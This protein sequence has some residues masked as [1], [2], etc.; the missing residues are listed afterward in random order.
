M[1]PSLVAWFYLLFFFYLK[2]I[3]LLLFIFPFLILSSAV[4]P[5]INV[6]FI[7]LFRISSLMGVSNPPLVAIS[8]FKLTF[9]WPLVEGSHYLLANFFFFFFL[10][11]LEVDKTAAIINWLSLDC[12]NFG[13]RR[14][15]KLGRSLTGTGV[16]WLSTAVFR[17]VAECVSRCS[18]RR[19]PKREKKKKRDCLIWKCEASI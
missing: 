7:F 3:I 2:F 16:D 15:S 17:R 4:G 18:E 13:G 5:L 6:C 10:S 1:A 11:R 19:E 8:T 9:S 12:N 14:L